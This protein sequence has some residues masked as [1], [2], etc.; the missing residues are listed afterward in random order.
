M[1]GGAR[2]VHLT[3]SK[4]KNLERGKN[5]I[6]TLGREPSAAF[7]QPG[8]LAIRLQLH[9]LAHWKLILDDDS[10]S[11]YLLTEKRNRSQLQAGNRNYFFN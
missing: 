1:G 2:T 6:P 11:V 3:D 4:G 7:A 10:L 5:P 8:C 9:C